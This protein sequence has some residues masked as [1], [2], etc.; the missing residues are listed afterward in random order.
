MLSY[1]SQVHLF[2]SALHGALAG[3]GVGLC[4]QP[5]Q[6]LRGCICAR[7]AAR[8]DVW[9]V[10]MPCESC[11]GRKEATPGRQGPNLGRHVQ[12]EGL[13]RIDT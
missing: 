6:V 3:Q 9:H 13:F 4:G 11:V 2:L 1:T 7:P 12:D 5:G 8:C 10:T